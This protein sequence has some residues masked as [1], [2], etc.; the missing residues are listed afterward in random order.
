LRVFFFCSIQITDWLEPDNLWF[1]LK[2]T[3]WKNKLWFYSKRLSRVADMEGGWNQEMSPVGLLQE[4][5]GFIS[6]IAP[7]GNNQNFQS[8]TTPFN[9]ELKWKIY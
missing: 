6:R 8:N 5:N 4:P 1:D 9:F 7:H 3:W 2:T